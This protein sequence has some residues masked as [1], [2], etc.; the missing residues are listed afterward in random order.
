MSSCRVPVALG[1]DPN[2]F[3]KGFTEYHTQQL[4]LTNDLVNPSMP[5]VQ[6]TQTTRWRW[7]CL[8]AECRPRAGT[9]LENNG[10]GVITIISLIHWCH[11]RQLRLQGSSVFNTLV[12]F[13]AFFI[14]VSW[15]QC[16]Q[17]SSVPGHVALGEAI[18]A[19]WH[20]T[21]TQKPGAIC[22]VMSKTKS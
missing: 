22:R 10:T 2:I 14:G 13:K 3:G 11:S 15:P 9:K 18:S 1:E 19:M 12:S 21:D 16:L 5:S 8:S 20:V 7:W 17:G 4:A 6:K